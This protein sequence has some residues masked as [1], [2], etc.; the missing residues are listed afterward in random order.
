M[1]KRNQKS[2]L[3]HRSSLNC[4]HT[5]AVQKTFQIGR[6]R[7]VSIFVVLLTQ[8]SCGSPANTDVW[9]RTGSCPS[10][11]PHPWLSHPGEH[12]WSLE[13][14]KV[15]IYITTVQ[16]CIPFTRIIPHWELTVAINCEENTADSWK[17]PGRGPSPAA[18]SRADQDWHPPRPNSQ[19]AAVL[20]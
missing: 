18:E 17:M 16:C 19:Q 13:D 7:L 14:T 15:W 4:S 6:C 11:C 3:T 10:H 8:V 1:Y 12:I 5:E 9:P 2:T 20:S